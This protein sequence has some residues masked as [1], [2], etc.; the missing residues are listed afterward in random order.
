VT[1]CGPCSDRRPLRPLL[2]NART[3]TGRLEADLATRQQELDDAR[4]ALAAAE[5][6]ASRVEGRARAARLLRD[7]L[8]SHCEA[9]TA[10]CRPASATLPVS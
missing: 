3:V 6:E 1:D 10:S 4:T 5:S 2:D 9:S 8:L 7:T